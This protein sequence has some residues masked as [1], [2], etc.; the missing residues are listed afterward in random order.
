V[1]EHD[2]VRA[3]GRV[4]ATPGL[5]DA[6]GPSELIARSRRSRANRPPSHSHC[7]SARGNRRQTDN[8]PNTRCDCRPGDANKR[9]IP[10][11]VC[12]SEHPRSTAGRFDRFPADNSRRFR[13]RVGPPEQTARERGFS[14]SSRPGK[15]SL[16]AGS[17]RHLLST[18]TGPEPVISCVKGARFAGTARPGC[19]TFVLDRTPPR[20]PLDIRILRLVHTLWPRSRTPTVSCVSSCG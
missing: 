14:D 7:P 18:P 1:T 17:G 4:R 3:V 8:R 5:G 12:W 6:S 16:K 9:S 2:P 13:S 10:A 20:S 15:L 11:S 19:R